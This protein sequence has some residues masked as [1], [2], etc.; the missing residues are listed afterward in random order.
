MQKIAHRNV[1]QLGGVCYD[2]QPILN[3]LELLK[4]QHQQQQLQQPFTSNKQQQFLTLN[5]MNPN[6]N[7]HGIKAELFLNKNKDSMQ[8][9][10]GAALYIIVVLC[11]YSLSILFM[12]LFNIKLRCFI[13]SSS[14]GMLCCDNHDNDLYESQMD[15]TKHTIHM[16]FNDSSKLLSSVV[17][18]QSTAAAKHR[19]SSRP[20]SSK[21][22]VDEEQ[23]NSFYIET[24]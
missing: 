13:K 7:S 12:V 8:D 18:N 15:E 24:T 5:G 17:L 20:S 14:A 19:D 3:N 6:S 9:D 4:K 21:S 22:M 16:I 2:A 1:S 23:I 11:F 10:D